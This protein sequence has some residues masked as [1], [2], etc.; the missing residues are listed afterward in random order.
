MPADIA[1]DVPYVTELLRREALMGLSP[2]TIQQ[3]NQQT[4]S[5][6]SHPVLAPPSLADLKSYLP[7]RSAKHA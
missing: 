5:D 4:V 3:F 1:L 7:L 2:K 6:A